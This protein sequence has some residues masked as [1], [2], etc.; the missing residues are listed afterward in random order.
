MSQIQFQENKNEI[1]IDIARQE[2]SYDDM[3][4]HGLGDDFEIEFS[5]DSEGGAQ[6]TK[7]LREISN[8]NIELFRNGPK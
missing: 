1:K 4:S 6:E 2:D 7:R 3:V 8:K 5:D